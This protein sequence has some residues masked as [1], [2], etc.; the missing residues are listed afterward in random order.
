MEKTEGPK[1]HD[2]IHLSFKGRQILFFLLLFQ[3]KKKV[4]TKKE[5]LLELV[6]TG[7]NWLELDKTG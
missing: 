3:A 5:N 6:R 2:A 1:T 4:L 7:K